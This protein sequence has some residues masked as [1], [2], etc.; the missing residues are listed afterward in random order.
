MVDSPYSRRESRAFCLTCAI[1]GTTYWGYATKYAL[2]LLDI[3]PPLLPSVGADW[4]STP[5]LT[6]TGLF[7]LHHT[8]A[9]C[10]SVA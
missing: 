1:L 5:G 3:V 4:A 10:T 9:C 7:R 2:V 6:T 8:G